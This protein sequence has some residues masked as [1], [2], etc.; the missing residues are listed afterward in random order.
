MWQPNGQILQEPQMLRDFAIQYQADEFENVSK[1][2][3][4]RDHFHGQKVPR[5]FIPCLCFPSEYRKVKG[6]G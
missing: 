6:E 4:M 3:S 2:C 1:E 5:C